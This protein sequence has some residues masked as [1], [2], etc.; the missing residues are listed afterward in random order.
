MGTRAAGATRFEPRFMGLCHH[1][2]L[3]AQGV[4]QH[5][6]DVRAVLVDPHAVMLADH[7]RA[8]VAH[9]LC[10][11]VIRGYARGKQLAGIGVP[12]LAR[13]AITNACRF[14]MRFEEPVP[15][16]EVADVRQAAL[17]VQEYKVQVVLTNGLVVA[18]DDLD[19]VLGFELVD[20]V[21]FA[22]GIPRWFQQAYFAR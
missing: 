5:A 15:Y 17:G 20:G 7:V 2:W 1:W 9:L 8:G 3:D 16:D 14:Q 19:R 22:Q 10:N 6:D 21:Q 18:L 12:A 13:S 4:L 11:P